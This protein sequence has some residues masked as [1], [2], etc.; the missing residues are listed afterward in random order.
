MVLSWF[1]NF[2]IC[3]G[4]IQPDSE[5]QILCGSIQLFSWI[6]EWFKPHWGKFN[7]VCAWFTH[8]SVISAWF[9]PCSDM[10]CL[11]GIASVR[12]LFGP[13][14]VWF[15]V[16]LTAWRLLVHHGSLSY[17]SCRLWA[18]ILVVAFLHESHNNHST[19]HVV[20]FGAILFEIST[21]SSVLTVF[22]DSLSMHPLLQFLISLHQLMVW[23]FGRIRTGSAD[24]VQVWGYLNQPNHTRIG[25]TV[26]DQIISEPAEVVHHSA[27]GPNPNFQTLGCLHLTEWLN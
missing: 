23:G 8:S 14:F 24:L 1:N 20:I 21:G 6:F 13:T 9:S 27:Q 25:R 17:S 22:K 4:L 12:G 15:I 7:L 5:S 19:A 26:P 10:L 2:L 16:L 11:F 18:L 3:S